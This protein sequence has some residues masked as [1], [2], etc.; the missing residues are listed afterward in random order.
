MKL[1]TRLQRNHALEHATVHLL[2][3]TQPGVSLVGRTDADGFWLYGDLEQNSIARAVAEGLRLL[4]SGRSA[5]AVHPRCGTNMAVAIL[6]GGGV[7]ALLRRKQGRLGLGRLL[8]AGVA[9]VGALAWSQPLGMWVQKR[10]TT[11]ADLG[12]ARITGVRR[13][14]LPGIVAHHVLVGHEN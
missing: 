1:T 13:Q 7:A 12:D 5:L 10:L 9:L 2:S 14:D 11:T 8:A 4:R 3:Q 6:M